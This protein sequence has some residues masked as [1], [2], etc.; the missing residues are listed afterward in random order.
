MLFFGPKRLGVC[1]KT[2][3]ARRVSKRQT[4]SLAACV[5]GALCVRAPSTS[6][7]VV[8][9]SSLS[10]NLLLTIDYT[11]LLETIQ[12]SLIQR[13]N[14]PPSAGRILLTRL[15]SYLQHTCEAQDV[16]RSYHP[17]AAIALPSK[18]SAKLLAIYLARLQS[19]IPSDR[20]VSHGVQQLLP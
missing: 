5:F 20:A 19:F 4:F 1:R 12:S 18:R 6:T 9:L 2:A 15:L 8:S 17:P 11:C 16:V 10:S 7:V 3:A 14:S 13:N